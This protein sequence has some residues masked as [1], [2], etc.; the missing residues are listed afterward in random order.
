[1]TG[2]VGWLNLNA[3]GQAKAN[4]PRFT[5]WT[6]GVSFVPQ[7]FTANNA[8]LSY[9][10]DENA[11]TSRSTLGL[12]ENTPDQFGIWN[13]TDT[14]LMDSVTPSPGVEYRLNH[15]QATTANRKIYR[16]GVGTTDTLWSRNHI[17]RKSVV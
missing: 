17:D 6:M 11:N 5:T 4:V 15:T 14:W 10:Q 3:L 13:S 12:C 2:Q 1:M 16:N 8:I 9:T 7:N